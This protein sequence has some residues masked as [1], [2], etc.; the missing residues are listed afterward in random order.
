MIIC[1]ECKHEFFLKSVKIDETF[2][3]LNDTTVALTYFTCPKCNKIYRVLI[4][5]R[6]YYELKE[7][8]E[9]TRRKMYKKNG[10]NDVKVLH[11]MV[12]KKHER[13]KTYVDKVNKMFPGTFIFEASENNQ[14]KKKIVYLP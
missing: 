11:S 3:E 12:V 6:R 7:D 1:D 9:K 8:L 5:D 10:S 4:K 14:E 13:L 2:V